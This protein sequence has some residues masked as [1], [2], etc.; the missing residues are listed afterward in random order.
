[1]LTWLK[2][3]PI[4]LS[5]KCKLLPDRTEVR[6]LSSRKLVLQPKGLLHRLHQYPGNKDLR[7]SMSR[8]EDLGALLGCAGLPVRVTPGRTP[9]PG[10]KYSVHLLFKLVVFNY[11]CT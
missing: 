5:Y 10:P 4:A 1:M 9:G 2:C 11:L 7:R 3:L 8:V 6:C